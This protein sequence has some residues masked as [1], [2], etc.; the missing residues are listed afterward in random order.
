MEK[1]LKKKAYGILIIIMILLLP[2]C[3]PSRIVGKQTEPPMTTTPKSNDSDIEDIVSEKQQE[4]IMIEYYSLL[5]KPNNKN[6]IIDFIDKN[7]EI[8]DRENANNMIINLEE[9][10]SSNN[11]SFQESY[12]LLNRYKRYVSLETKSYINILYTESSDSFIKEDNIIIDLEDILN[13]GLV[14]E[15]HMK[16]FSNGETKE[17]VSKMYKEY[18]K[19]SIIGVGNPYIYGEEGTSILKQEVFDIYNLIIEENQSTKTRNILFKYTKILQDNNRDMNSE[20]VNKFY[21]EIDSIIEEEL[22]K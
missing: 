16:V 20:E 7:I 2:A 1:K 11:Y 9:Y 17:K 10:L 21:D 13:R 18:I 22:K 5:N 19:A 8:L 6:Q 15:N 14:A 4:S 3:N 12:I